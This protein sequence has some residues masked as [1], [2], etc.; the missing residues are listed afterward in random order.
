MTAIAVVML[1][2]VVLIVGVV[3]L[4]VV[5]A[6]LAVVTAGKILILKCRRRT[7]KKVWQKKNIN[8]ELTESR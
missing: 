2:V 5:L 8:K 4:L 3:I 7:E 6:V 1:I